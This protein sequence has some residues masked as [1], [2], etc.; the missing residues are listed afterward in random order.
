MGGSRTRDRVR[1]PSSNLK[2]TFGR[3]LRRTMA[4]NLRGQSDCL[5]CSCFRRRAAAEDAR[6]GGKTNRG[7]WTVPRDVLEIWLYLSSLC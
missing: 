7:C 6:M 3:C 2:S 5:T 1:S 4:G